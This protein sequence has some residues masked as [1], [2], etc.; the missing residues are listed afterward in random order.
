MT[1]VVRVARRYLALVGHGTG[2]GWQHRKE[3]D[4]AVER[5]IEAMSPHLKSLWRKMKIQFKGSPQRR[6]E[7]FLEYVHHHSDEAMEL[8]QDEADRTLAKM[9]KDLERRHWE[10]VKDQPAEPDWLTDHDDDDNL[11]DDDI[12]FA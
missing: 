1:L 8:L 3:R 11:P 2:L 9:I 12:P 4:E 6:V 7:L 5:D 10:P